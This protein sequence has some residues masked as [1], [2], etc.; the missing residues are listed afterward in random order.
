MGERC[1]LIVV[2]FGSVV[3]AIRQAH[4]AKLHLDMYPEAH[5]M[6]AVSGFDN[7]SRELD[8]IPEARVILRAFGDALGG[9]KYLCRFDGAGMGIILLAMGDGTAIREGLDIIIRADVAQK[10]V[11]ARE[12]WMK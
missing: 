4:V 1:M 9:T 12:E 6:V 2:E 8:Q 5:A 3:E 11:V 10:L 7:D